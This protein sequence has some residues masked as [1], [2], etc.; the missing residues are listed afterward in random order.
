MKRIIA[1]FIVACLSANLVGCS[2]DSVKETASSTA[3]QI[4][5]TASSAAK[6]I[7]QIAGNT[8]DAVVNWYSNLD[9][10]KFKDGWDYSVEFMGAKYNAVMSSQYVSGIESA[11]T[12]LKTDINSAAGTARG[13]AQE[14]G[15]L[16]EKWVSDTFNI[17][18]VANGSEYRTDVVGSTEFGSPDVTTNYGETV[19]LKYYKTA[20][21]SA[22]AQAK[23]LLEAYKEYCGKTKKGET[24]TLAEYM[25]ER[26]YDPQ[27]QS[28]LLP[29]YEGQTRIIPTEQL[30]EAQLYLQGKIDKLSSI[31]GNAASARTKA[32][33]DTL[34]NLKDRLKASDGTESKPLSYKEAQAI[35]ELSKDGEFKPEDF[36]INVSTVISPKYVVKQ[37][38]GT[39]LE[40]AA[41]NTVLTIG[42]DIYSIIKEAVQT[43][44]IDEDALKE[45]GIEGAIAASE[46]FVEGS[47]SRVVTTLCASGVLGET[48]KEAS[49]SI[50][51]TLT[52]LVIEASIHGYELSQGKITAEEY[53]N[54]MVDRLMVSLI[55]LPTSALF[56][57]ILPATH[58]AMLAGCM[59]GGMVACL[60]YMAAKSAIMDIVDGGGFEAL[61]PAK[62]TNTISVA[63]E[64]I[65]SLN[66]QE[67]VSSFTDSVVS[68]AKDGYIK[69]SSLV[70]N[71]K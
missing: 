60:G 48:L 42:P 6:Q 10:S 2:L 41:I 43:K 21:G 1:F 52:V 18:A 64:T 40:V 17:N 55:A 39:G 69:V 44:D 27:T 67:Q 7:G 25:N 50:V 53:G 5:Q 35:A 16:A 33:Q 51:A 58:I 45:S 9:F 26:G 71:D 65:A 4:G 15:F 14:A 20:E 59:A 8:K 37:A 24:P 56:L 28:D 62:V 34:S 12:T 61:I 13:T 54:M 36:G 47:V 11:I 63:S 31:E 38:V 68:T 23:T 32:Y 3:S 22:S 29:V 66:I 70:S 49:P 19:S 30:Q 46:G 57:A